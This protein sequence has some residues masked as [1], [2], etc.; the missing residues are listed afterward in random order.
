[1][2]EIVI[3]DDEGEFYGKRGLLGTSVSLVEDINGNKKYAEQV[4]FLD[5]INANTYVYVRKYH[6]YNKPE[7]KQ[8]IEKEEEQINYSTREYRFLD[9]ED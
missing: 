3:I 6:K 9:I 1:M 8:V 2:N 5:G 4:I 7:D